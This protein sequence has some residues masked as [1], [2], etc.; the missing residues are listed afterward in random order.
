MRTQVAGG[1]RQLY[2]RGV[3]LEGPPHAARSL[4]ADVVVAVQ[5]QPRQLARAT[6]QQQPPE[7]LAAFVADAVGLQVQLAQRT[8]TAEQRF[9]EG[10]RARDSDAVA[11]KA[12]LV[13]TC[14]RLSSQHHIEWNNSAACRPEHS[15]D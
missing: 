13:E 9:G 14:A 15:S 4:A 5:Q 11:S 3:R 8:V 7:R 1:Q 6:R 10:A 12:Q 2:Q